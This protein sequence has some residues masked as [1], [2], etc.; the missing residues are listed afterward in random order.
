M[1]EADDGGDAHGHDGHDGPDIDTAEVEPAVGDVAI[2]ESVTAGTA[3]LFFVL[4]EVGA[5][6][7]YMYVS[8]PMWFFLDEWDFLA[9]RTA[10]NLHDLFLPHNE[11]LVALPVLVYRGLWWLFGLRTYRPYQLV[12]VLLHLAL[13]LL[14]RTV[15]RRVGVRPWTATLVASILV[16]FGSGYQNIVLPFQITL[17]G[18]VVFGLVHLLLAGHEGPWDRRD[19]LGLA[20]GLG[21]LLC[22]G[23]G[24]SMV[25][26]V[27]VA[28][29]ISRGWRPALLHTLPLAAIYGVWFVA[30][31]HEGYTRATKHGGPADI[32]RFVR[33]TVADTFDAIGHFRG[34]GVVLGALI[35]V[36]L[37]LAWRPLP[38][39]ELRSRAAAPFGLLI[40]AFSLLCITGFGRAGQSSITENSRYLHLVAAML[41]PALAV[42]ADAVMRR[43]RVAA[44][45]VAVVLLVGIPG[46]L[47]V[48]AKY[49]HKPVVVKQVEYRNLILSL[50]RVAAAKEVPRDTIPEHELAHFVTI[51]WLLDGAASGRIPKPAHISPAD[52][53]MDTIRLSL[54][55][56][57]VFVAPDEVCVGLAFTP[58]VFHLQTG[59]TIL[60]HSAGKQA[61]IVLPTP[62]PGDPFPFFPITVE[63]PLMTAQRPVAFRIVKGG[64]GSSSVCAQRDLVNAARIAAQR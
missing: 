22:S 18:S 40:G 63:G 45:A 57:P 7:F 39:A 16:F 17:V 11:H 23:V 9:N 54:K 58:L 25:I 60:V 37:V 32:A 33:V 5:L 38:A 24:V 14:V 6:V 61:R 26:A 27:G 50:P 15:M 30:I 28:V 20:A 31:G 51:G 36:G 2:D 34:V 48:I 1:S 53:A 59:Q 13:C 21:A 8:R 19:S 49:M 29:L 4:G 42:A 52:E 41:L 47:N 10:F 56:S 3:L 44:P 12:I 46:N 43:W 55:Q 35:V 62:E 64:P